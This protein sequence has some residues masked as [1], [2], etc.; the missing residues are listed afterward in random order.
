MGMVGED[1]PCCLVVCA[2]RGFGGCLVVGARGM[3]YDRLEPRA[4][5]SLRLL[6]QLR[7]VILVFVGSV[8]PLVVRVMRES[9]SGWERWPCPTGG[10][11]GTLARIDEGKY[12]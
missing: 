8:Q 9:G 4:G 3:D 6:R 10:G 5:G 2:S 1:Y 12:L 11:L 7:Y